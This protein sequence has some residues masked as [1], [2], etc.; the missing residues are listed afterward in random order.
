MEDS[1]DIQPACIFDIDSSIGKIGFAGDRTPQT[2]S[3]IIGIAR[4]NNISQDVRYGDDALRM[5]NILKLIRP[6]KYCLI[7]DWKN[8]VRQLIRFIPCSYVATILYCNR[9]SC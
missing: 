8:M 1:D 5:K 9:R 4:P 6:V 7:S 3:T 2:F